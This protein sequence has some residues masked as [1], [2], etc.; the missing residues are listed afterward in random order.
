M[1]SSQKLKKFTF[2]VGWVF[3]S[4]IITIFIGFLLRVFLGRFL[5]P[6][7]LGLYAMSFSVYSLAALVGGIGIPAATVKFVGEY[8]TDKEKLN[9]FMS[10]ALINSTIFGIIVCFI[11]FFSSSMIADLFN[12]PELTSLIKIIAIALPFLVFNNTLLLGLFTGLKNIKL[13][14]FGMACR[15]ILLLSLAVLLVIIG[16]GV[17]GAVSAIM[18]AEMGT[19]ILSLFLTRKH[20]N[21]SLQDYPQVTRMLI[22]FGAQ[23]F[24]ASAIYMVN[25]FA[26]R[27]FIAYF[28]TDKDVGIYAIALAIA[29][30]LQ[31]IPVAISTVTY[32]MMS[33]YNNKGIRQTNE[34]LINKVMKYTLIIL[35]ILG[36]L[37]IFFAKDIILLLLGPEFLPGVMPLT[38]LV[39]GIIFFG[40]MASIGSAFS[41]A[42]RPDIPLKL[43]LIVLV[44]NIGLD[45]VLIP[46]LGITGA[47]IGTAVSLSVLTIL[48]I[49]LLRRILKI[50]TE[51]KCYAQV[52]I[53]VATMIAVFF[54]FQN[55]V[56]PYFIAGV[57]FIIYFTVAIRFLLK[58]EDRGELKGM[59]R[60]VF[61]S[62]KST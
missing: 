1:E 53:A 14:G 35:S 60:G 17:K 31:M 8:K 26:D 33:E 37:I 46:R 43:N 12:M 25:T 4:R 24:L 21:F 6:G 20:F 11:L 41:A 19:F 39:L 52:L 22:P 36:I 44:V 15:S 56:N 51:I 18:F 55:W 57:L 49:Y 7:G 10:S 27:L 54:I 3:A 61:L 16:W 40:S 5:G 32:P 9:A 58:S 59:L 29:S 23:L 47:A 30:A 13:Y 48:T 50:K 42:G 38:I 62:R 28:L 45:V 34:T 2:D